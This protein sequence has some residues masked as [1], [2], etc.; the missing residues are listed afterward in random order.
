MQKLVGYDANAFYLW[1]LSQPMPAGLF[2]TW[3]P[4]GEGLKPN[5]S[6]RTADEWLPWISRDLTHF[7][8]RLDDG[9]KCLRPRQLPV[10][11]YD[12][13]TW[14]VYEFHGCYWHGH[15]SWLTA[16]K[17]SS[18]EADPDSPQSVEFLKLM[19]ERRER[20]DDKSQYLE[21]LPALT[22]VLMSERQWYRQKAG[23]ARQAI[24]TFL[25]QHFPGR[26]E[27]QQSL[28]QLL[29]RVQEGSF[30]RVLEVDIETPPHLS[31]KFGEMTPIFKNVAMGRTEVGPHMQTFD[32]QHDIMS[33]P[34]RALIG[35]YKG[36]KIL[37]G[38]PLLNF[39]LHE[40]LVVTRVHRAVQWRSHPW[41]EPLLTL[42]PCCVTPPMQ[43]PTERSWARRL[44]G[45]AGFG[46]FVM[47]VTLHLEINYKKEESKVDRAINSVF[48]HDLDE[49]SDEVFELKMY[50]KKI[51]CDL[52]IRIGFFV[53]T[54]AK[55]RM[56]EFYYHCI[57][58]YLDRRDFQFLEMDIDSAYMALAGDSLEALV[59]PDKMVEFVAAQH[60]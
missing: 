15:P 39:Y 55:L 19:R 3:T 20:T 17:L 21:S 23:Q 29:H 41:L 18:A 60:R 28:A 26:S 52:P 49:L 31:D 8:T 37:L 14:T 40:G 46:R 32:E 22:V 5:K 7:C 51:K 50:K 24:E 56:L 25:D 1:A 59:K 48:S 42:C 13:D 58:A 10:D 4:C 11:G 57:D 53:F 34:Q 16:A 9:K 27:K 45:N 2:T 30:F 38:T 12:A 6:W 54:Y 44:V 35:S 36:D 43:T 47:D 33:T